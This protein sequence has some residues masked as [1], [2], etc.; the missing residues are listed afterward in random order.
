MSGRQSHI[1]P[2][3]GVHVPAGRRGE[4][5]RRVHVRE[6]VVAALERELGTLGGA[7]IEVV[8]HISGEAPHDAIL[9]E[10]IACRVSQSG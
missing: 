4:A 6:W 3:V 1:D 10:N 8:A 7:G 2:P 5:I 9:R